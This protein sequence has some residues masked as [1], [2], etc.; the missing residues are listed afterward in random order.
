MGHAE[1]TVGKAKKAGSWPFGEQQHSCALSCHCCCCCCRRISP[2]LRR[3]AFYK[4]NVTLYS[5]KKNNH[6]TCLVMRFLASPRSINNNTTAVREQYVRY[7]KTHMHPHARVHTLNCSE[8][9]SGRLRI[10][11][12]SLLLQVSRTGS[13]H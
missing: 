4:S 12:C 13:D 3:E 1:R 11:P 10:Q 5:S 8:A 7:F 2:R 9:V 6:H